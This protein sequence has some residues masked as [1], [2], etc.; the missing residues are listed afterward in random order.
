MSDNRLHDVA[1]GLLT[2][3]ENVLNNA[4]LAVPERRYITTGQ[5]AEEGCD[6]LVVVVQSMT[7]GLPN[8]GGGSL[9]FGAKCVWTFSTAIQIH[10][11][12]CGYPTSDNLE[13]PSADGITDFSAGLITDG[14]TLWAGV[15]SAYNNGEIIPRCSTFLPRS[16]EA[17]GP[18]AGVAGWRMNMWIQL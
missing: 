4:G 5:Y 8:G 2:V 17:V 13:P 6:Q 11:L 10:L 14:W 3:A 12:R 16:L 1:V 9:R 18:R 7:F 15:I